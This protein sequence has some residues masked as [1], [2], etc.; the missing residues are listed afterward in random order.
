MTRLGD[1]FYNRL[2][3]PGTRMDRI[4][5]RVSDLNNFKVGAPATL[6]ESRF[7]VLTVLGKRKSFRLTH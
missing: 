7:Q 5:G 4:A 1:G 6:V 2:R 3:W